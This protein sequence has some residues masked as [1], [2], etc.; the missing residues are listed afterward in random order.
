LIEC[1]PEIDFSS[2]ET[3]FCFPEDS[4]VET[5]TLKAWSASCAEA[6]QSIEADCT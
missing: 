1:Y 2:Y 6:W 3:S 5:E 4:V